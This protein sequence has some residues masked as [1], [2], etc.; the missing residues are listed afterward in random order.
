LKEAPE[1]IAAYDGTERRYF[2][3]RARYGQQFS[4]TGTGFF[5]EDP[6]SSHR[7]TDWSRK[8]VVVLSSGGG[9][10][11]LVNDEAILST[12]ALTLEV[13]GDILANI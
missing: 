1:L 2:E 4:G 5:T 9:S 13:T 10:G 12:R 3:W 7:D 11:R 6:N 8:D